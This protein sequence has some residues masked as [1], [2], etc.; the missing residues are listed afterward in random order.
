MEQLLLVRSLRVV[1]EG[2]L[3]QLLWLLANRFVPILHSV[4]GGCREP[5]LL[6]DHSAPKLQL[7]QNSWKVTTVP[8]L[9]DH[10]ASVLRLV[11]GGWM[12]MPLLVDHVSLG[13]FP[14]L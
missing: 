12:V 7:R 2:G 9:L 5:L 10:S 6:V 1:S 4:R 13:L 8:V 3:E 14:V 11:L